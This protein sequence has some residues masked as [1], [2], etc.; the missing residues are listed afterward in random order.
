MSRLYSLGYASEDIISSV[1]RVCRNQTMPEYLML[2]FIQVH[3]FK[4]YKILYV[5]LP[6]SKLLGD[7]NEPH[8]DSTR[9]GF[10]VANVGSSS[11]TLQ[12]SYSAGEIILKV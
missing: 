12:E 1:F 9:F 7:W 5:A 10:P 11:S 2:E 6:D 3:S 4:M 8:Q